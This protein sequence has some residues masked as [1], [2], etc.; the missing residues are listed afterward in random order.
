MHDDHKNANAATL[1][2]RFCA[3]PCVNAIFLDNTSKPA[4]HN[5]E[6][7]FQHVGLSRGRVTAGQENK[8][9]CCSVAE[10]STLFVRGPRKRGILSPTLKIHE[11]IRKISKTTRR[12]HT[13]EPVCWLL[14]SKRRERMVWL[15]H[16]LSQQCCAGT[17]LSGEVNFPAALDIWHV[18]IW[19]DRS[20]ERVSSHKAL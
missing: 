6:L 10:N 2:M 18:Y 17:H 8:C 20:R 19:W 12:R 4:G 7:T 9:C 5:Q 15:P 13:S 1:T 11:K 3:R 14:R 16:R